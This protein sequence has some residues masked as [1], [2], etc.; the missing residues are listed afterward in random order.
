MREVNGKVRGWKVEA[1]GAGLALL[2]GCGDNGPGAAAPRANLLAASVAV[3][4]SPWPVWSGLDFPYD[5]P[6]LAA[7]PAVTFGVSQLTQAAAQTTWRGAHTLAPGSVQDYRIGVFLHGDVFY[8]QADATATIAANGTFTVTIPR[9][10]G[11][12]DRAVLILYPDGASPLSASNCN[13]AAGTCSGRVTSATKL[14]LPL[15]PATLS[16]YTASYFPAATT[17]ANP[18]IAGLQALMN[19][20]TIDGGP[21]GAGKLVRSFRDMDS[22]FLYDQALAVIAFSLAG[23]QAHADLVLNAMARLQGPSGAWVF[24]YLTDGSDANPG[25]DMRIAGA[26]AWLGIALNTYQKAFDSTRYL[27]MSKKLHDYLLGELVGITVNNAA[28]RSLRF[29][30]TNYV[31]GRA[32]IHALEHQLDAYASMHQYHALNGGSQYLAAANDLR[33]MAESLWNGSRFLGGYDANT[34]TLNTSER[35]L[36]NY[37]WSVL[38]LGNTGSSGQNFAAALPAMCDYVT[39]TGRLDYP[40]RKVTGIVGFYDAIYDGAPSSAPFVWSEGSLGAI[41]AMRQGA[42]GM[43]CA[44]NTADDML[45]SLNY[46]AGKLHAMPYATRNGNADFTSSGSV[47]G[48]AWQYFALQRKN[49]YA[50]F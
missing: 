11:N 42:P 47:A 8:W 10:V 35:Y 45:E 13:A 6:P 16:A 49:P 50:H 1:L 26:N 25:V 44:G 17:S 14:S 38:A 18:Q 33:A 7:A 3:Q 48:T 12:A 36:D 34:N 4:A 23:D 15:D 9:T 2:A 22:A 21:Y 5:E 39:A 41:M 43:T 28:R 24:A 19:T 27:A 29:A 20:D 40:S 37:S 46:M 32:G 31:A 30:P